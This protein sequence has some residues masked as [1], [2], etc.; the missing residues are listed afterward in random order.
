MTAF[1]HRAAFTPL[2]RWALLADAAA[3]A[4]TGLLLVFGGGM[5]HDLLGL[6]EQLMLYAGLSLLP[7][8]MLVA[9]MATRE[10]PYRAAIW[11]IIAYNVLW[12]VDSL[13]LLVSGFVTPTALGVAF[14][15]AQALAVAGFGALQYAGMMQT[16]A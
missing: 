8:A 11:A 6:P 2:L 3:S 13:V 5:L 4:T 9:L 16:K 14:I 10:R 15:F 1:T 7:F 12:A